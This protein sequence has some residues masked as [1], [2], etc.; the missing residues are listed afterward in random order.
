MSNFETE[1]A[2][3]ERELEKIDPTELLTKNEELD[4]IQIFDSTVEII[5]YI[6]GIESP[7]IVG[8]NQQYKILKFFLNNSSGRRIQIVSWN[9]DIDRIIPYI[10]PNHVNIKKNNV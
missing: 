10:I 3:L 5:G 6:D 8:N 9:D 1:L 7:R 2:N 4:A